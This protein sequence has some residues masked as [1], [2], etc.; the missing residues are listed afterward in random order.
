MTQ[1]RIIRNRL[2]L[3]RLAEE[4][5]NVSKA[6]KFLGYSRDTFYRY[7][8]LAEEGGLEALREASRKG[9]PNL[10]NRVSSEIETRILELSV[11][12][13]TWGQTR[14]RN[15]LLKEN[16]AISTYRRSWDLAPTRNGDDGEA[17]GE[18]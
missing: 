7:K 3:L 18:A 14:M 8:D 13:P 16:I 10:R 6:C 15:E 17:A 2:G 11:E 5:G 12:Q 9:K 4:L 1:E